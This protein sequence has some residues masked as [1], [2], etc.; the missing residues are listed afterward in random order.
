MARQRQMRL[1]DVY[2]N[3]GPFLGPRTTFITAFPTIEELRVEVNEAGSR[4][5]GLAGSLVFNETSI[6]EFFNCTNP[7]CTR[8]GIRIGDVIRG[9]VSA[10]ETKCEVELNCEGCEGSPKGRKIFGPCRN[11]FNVKISI[12]YKQPVNS[13]QIT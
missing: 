11:T 8:G 13:S 7:R 1:S 9:M 4:A 5:W 12:R 2:A 10:G 6:S 3:G